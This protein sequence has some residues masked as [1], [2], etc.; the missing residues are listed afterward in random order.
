MRNLSAAV[1][2]SCST[3]RP[4]NSNSDSGLFLL[5]CSCMSAVRP[6][7]QSAALVMH[8]SAAA[9]HPCSTVSAHMHER[10]AVPSAV[11]QDEG[12]QVLGR[13]SVH[14]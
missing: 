7:S 1:L 13:S 8:S 14:V 11:G 10:S 6:I 5:L 3:G 9:A 2:S 4:H 12:V